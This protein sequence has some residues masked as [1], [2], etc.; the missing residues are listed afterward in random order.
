M[1]GVLIQG[2]A[3]V[4]A[5]VFAKIDKINEMRIKKNKEERSRAPIPPPTTVMSLVSKRHSVC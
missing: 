4:C 2:I 1:F 5:L 3:L